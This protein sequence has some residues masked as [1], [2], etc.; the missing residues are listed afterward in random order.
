MDE[1]AVILNIA[2]LVLVASAFTRAV[3]SPRIALMIGAAGFIVYGV[4]AS[5]ATVIVWN[6]VT[7]SLHALQL[8][9]YVSA[10]RAVHLTDDDERW[11]E[12]L[13]PGLDRFDFYSLWSMGEESQSSDR[14]LVAMGDDHNRVAVVLK[15]RVEVRSEDAVIAE[16]GEGALFGEMS[17]VRGLPANSDVHAV[18]EV[19]LRVWDQDRLRALDQLNPA[20]GRAFG[21]FVQRDLAT[22]LS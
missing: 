20:A 8:Y 5:I 6:A 9:R 15:G 17:F 1:S 14:R 10:R 13:F 2:Y 4:V 7:G 16:L 3:L 21:E 12:R 22:K 18:G 11:R 19:R